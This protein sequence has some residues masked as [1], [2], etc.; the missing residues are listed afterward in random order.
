[1]AAPGIDQQKKGKHPKRG[2]SASTRSSRG[3]AEGKTPAGGA[4]EGGLRSWADALVFAFVLAMFVRAFI[5]ELY[6]IPTGSMI[7]TLIGG[8]YAKVDWDGDGHEDL[9][10][11]QSP[12][13]VHPFLWRDGRYEESDEQSLSSG[14]LEAWKDEG[15]LRTQ[16]DHI[17]VSK[18]AYWFRNPRRGDI[19][20]FKVPELIFDPARPIYIKRLVG[21]PG[22]EIWFDDDG[23]I[24]WADGEESGA[25]EFFRHHRYRPYAQSNRQFHRFDYVD[26]GSMRGSRIPIDRIHVPPEKL[27]VLGDH[28]MSSLDS[29]YWGGFG[30]N[31]LKGKAFF[32]YWPIRQ[33]KF[34]R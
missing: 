14:Q 15:L 31:R 34:I 6:K 7:P 13:R 28:T 19:V 30:V 26:Y 12:W 18:F 2:P 27:Y 32:R 25:V 33:A 9:V 21:R 4:N 24:H 3:G 5:F 11:L 17:F 10:V 29:R 23:R 1:M 20:V 22:D 8:E 16:Y